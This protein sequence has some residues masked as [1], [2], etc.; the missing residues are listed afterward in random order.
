MVFWAD[1]IRD[2]ILSILTFEHPAKLKNLYQRNMAVFPEICY[3]R[4]YKGIPDK[5]SLLRKVAG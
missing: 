4:M 1:W 2:T 5:A 3:D